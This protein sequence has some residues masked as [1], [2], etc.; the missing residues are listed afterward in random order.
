LL[1][2]L[3]YT[4]YKRLAE[5]GCRGFDGFLIGGLFARMLLLLL[6]VVCLHQSSFLH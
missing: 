6:V 4:G 1:H 2:L 3:V 5:R